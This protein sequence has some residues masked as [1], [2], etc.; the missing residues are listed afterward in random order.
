[1]EQPPFGIRAASALPSGPEGASEEAVGPLER[2][3][4]ARAAASHDTVD[5]AA[6]PKAH[7]RDRG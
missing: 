7:Y 4:A 3:V 5:R 1:M 6:M 2:W